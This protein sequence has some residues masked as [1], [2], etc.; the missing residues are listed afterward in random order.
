MRQ[1]L[2]NHRQIEKETKNTWESRTPS[3]ES[4]FLGGG[5]ELNCPNLEDTP[6]SLGD[7]EALRTVCLSGKS[8]AHLI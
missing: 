8:E 1:I 7:Q 5:P 2:R 4:C 3:E 6:V